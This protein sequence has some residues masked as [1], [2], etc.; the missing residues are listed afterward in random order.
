MPNARDAGGLDI[1]N[2][3][4][5]GPGGGGK[6]SQYW[7]LPSPGFLY[8]FDPNALASLEGLDMEYEKFCPDLLD[9][10]VHPLSAK[11]GADSTMTADEP[12]TYTNWEK[13]FEDSLE[14][15]YLDK[16]AWIGMD[17]FTTF[18]DAV[19]DRVQYLNG[20]FGKQP[21]QADWTAQMFTIQNVFRSMA[22]RNQLFVATAHEELRQEGDGTG[23]MK[24]QPVMTGRLRVR[25]PLLFSNIFRCEAESDRAGTRFIMHTAPDN[26]HPYGRVSKRIREI[27]VNTEGGM[28]PELDVTIEDFTKASDYGLGSLLKKAGMVPAE[29]PTPAAKPRRGKRR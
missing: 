10:N 6:T 26:L 22:A 28:P 5:I 3:L 29:Q 21:E 24:Y 25:I 8:I 20:R 13:H 16:F 19:M 27:F 4:L 14:S 23:R 15:G 11:K 12:V 9:I 1:H 2:I 17:S 7:T 18:S